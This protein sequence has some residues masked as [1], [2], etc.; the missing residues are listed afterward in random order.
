MNCTTTDS[1]HFIE[2]EDRIKIF[3]NPFKR[4]ISIENYEAGSLIIYDFTGRLIKN[5][6]TNSGI[7]EIDIQECKAGMYFYEFKSTHK[8]EC[9]KI[10]KIQ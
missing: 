8:N 1:H 7:T 2:K 5:I 10:L 6:K 4:K 9:G 3:P